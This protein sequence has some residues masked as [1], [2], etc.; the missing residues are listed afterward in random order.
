MEHEYLR[1][2][3]AMID[4]DNFEHNFFTIKNKL[5]PGTKLCAVIKADA[6]GHGAVEIAKAA[7]DCGVDYL[8]VALIEEALE[9]RLSG[10]DAPILILGFTPREQF[11]KI[12]AY[13]ITQTVYDVDSVSALSLTAKRLSK[14]AKVHIKIDTGMSRLGFQ[15]IPSSIDEIEK[16]FKFEGIQVE[17]IFTHFAKAENDQDFTQEQF[18]RFREVVESIEDRGF[19]IPIKHVCNSAATQIYPSMH[20]NMARVGLILYGL[21]PSDDEKWRSFGL[22]PVMTVK[23]QISH[24]KPLKVGRAISYGGEFVTTRPSIIATIPVGYADGWSRKLSPRGEVLV[25]SQRAP[26]VGKICMDQL[27]VDVTEVK[28]D[29][30]VGDEVV[31]MGKM[32]DEEILAEEIAEK[33]GTIN[34]EIVCSLSR[35]VPRVYTRHGKI[36]KV[37]NMLEI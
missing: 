15:A 8:A 30:K 4:L 24:L 25:A 11:D 23:S 17:G 9:L 20:L 1:P 32:V 18:K 19:R 12:V 7:L 10:I 36:V 16:I 3:R 27:M 26:I 14:T 21:L 5:S 34:Y 33:V 28:A 37:H 22:K 29:V 6:Y 2:T 35:R 31:L 13:D